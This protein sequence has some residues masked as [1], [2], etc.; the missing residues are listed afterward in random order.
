[1]H[2]QTKAYLLTFV[3]VLFWA[4]AASAF[5]IALEH[6]TPY[7]LLFYAA[8]VS[9]LALLVIV[10]IQGKLAEL[11]RVSARQVG[12]AALLGFINPFFYYIVLFKAYALLPGQIAMSLN[13]GWPLALTLLSVP[14]LKQQLSRIQ[15]LAIVIS[16]IGAIII[17]TKGQLDGFQGLSRLGI[18][19][20]FASTIIWAFYWLLN[21]RDGQEPVIKLFLG[22][23]FGVGYCVLFSPLF[24]GLT[25]P[26]ARAFLPLAYIGLFEM[27]ITFVLWLTALQLSSTAARVGNLIYISPFLS[28]VFLWAIIGEQIHLAT[29]IGLFLI[30][31]SILYQELY[32]A[33]ARTLN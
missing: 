20:A 31:G 16:F 21:A 6:V 7:I 4:T 26:P 24:G 32:P 17:A 13:Y 30:V 29:F 25:L 22:F 12:K 28:L 2:Q 27:G 8:I 23:C 9:T 18:V 11:R 15:L 5:K 19:L 1:M 3:A 33:K 14:L 10:I